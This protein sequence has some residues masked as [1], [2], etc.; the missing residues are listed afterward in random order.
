MSIHF[1]H[2]IVACHDAAAS[3]QFWADMLGLEVGPPYGP[4]LPVTVDNGVT[5]D[6]AVAPG[7][8]QD[9]PTAHYAFLVSEE[10][11]DKGF[12]RIQERGLRYWADP[13]AQRE[14][15]INHN[16]GG[17][18]VYFFDPNGHALELLTVPYGGWPES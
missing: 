5:F 14:G 15:E 7:T 8:V 11:F 13:H 12:A 6:F 10:D 18:G 9:I 1:N 4:F 17:R 2:T 3:A 16:D